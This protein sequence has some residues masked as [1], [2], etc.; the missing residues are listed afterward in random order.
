MSKVNLCDWFEIY[1]V[2]MEGNE[3]LMI[4]LIAKITQKE[5]EHKLHTT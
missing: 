5:I 3:M 1:G 4:Y 2:R